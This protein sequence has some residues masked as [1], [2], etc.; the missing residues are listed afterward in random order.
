M[1]N[2]NQEKIKK[3]ITALIVLFMI[4]L[5]LSG[6]TAFPLETELQLVD[7]WTSQHLERSSGLREWIYLVF[8]GVKETYKRYPFIAYG[9][10]WLAFAHIVISLFF[11]GVIIDPV[12]NT[13]IIKTGII[14]CILII[15]LAMIAGHIR[16]IPI[17]WRM[18]DCSFGI[19][20][21]IPLL[22]AY[23]LTLKLKSLSG[24][25]PEITV[26]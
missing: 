11:I 21:I 22:I 8:T 3:Q 5:I 18:I 6:V 4:G 26:I 1:N 17:Y 14:A 24:R 25:N 10:D 12:R 13:F 16:N 20:G 2:M 7:N 9:T 19:F 15:P 23:R